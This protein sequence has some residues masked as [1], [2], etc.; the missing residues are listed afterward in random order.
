MVVGLDLTESGLPFSPRNEKYV[1]IFLSGLR[2]NWELTER[3]WSAEA[4][5]QTP[6]ANFPSHHQE[7]GGG[8]KKLNVSHDTSQIKWFL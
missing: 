5:L 7:A 8:L 2:G 6:A 3:V 4:S 1:W